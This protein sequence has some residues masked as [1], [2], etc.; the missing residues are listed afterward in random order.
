MKCH[1]LLLVLCIAAT[2]IAGGGGQAAF[3]LDKGTEESR[4]EAGR[5]E[6]RRQKKWKGGRRIRDGVLQ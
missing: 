3:Q 6:T 1:I 4:W 5:S 2:F